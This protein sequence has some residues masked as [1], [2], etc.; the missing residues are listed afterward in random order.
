MRQTSDTL[1]IAAD[2]RHDLEHGHLH[3]VLHG[4]VDVDSQGH[5]ASI[6]LAVMLLV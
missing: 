4:A 6:V 1:A 3:G 5:W 2:Q